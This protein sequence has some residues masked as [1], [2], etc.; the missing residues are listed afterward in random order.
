[1]NILIDIGHPA[2]VHYFRNLYYELTKTHCVWVSCKG[3]KIITD[4]LSAYAIPYTVLGLKANTLVNKASTHLRYIYKA[5]SLIRKH[6][7]D[8]AIGS[9]GIAVHA[10]KLTGI[11]SVLFDDDDQ[12]VQPLTARLV[13]PV[14]GHVVSPDCLAYE[15]IP[16]AV[17]YPGFQELAYLHPNWFHPDCHI[18]KRMGVNPEAPYF[19]LRF[20]AFKAHHDLGEGGMSDSQKNALIRLLEREGHVYI[21]TES[22]LEPE[23]ERYRLPVQPH[24]MHSFLFFASMLVSDSQTMTSE[25]A[26]LGVPSFRCNSFV[27]RISYLEEEEKRYGLTY[28][29][30]PLRFQWMIEKIQM[31]IEKKRDSGY[32][33]AK[34]DAL[35][36][37]KIDVTAYWV[38]LISN[39]P[40]SFYAASKYGFDYDR[41][42]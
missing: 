39:Y 9:S 7:I 15:A 11:D 21:T 5:A 41:F 2:H 19:I 16:R 38:W 31:T 40:Y 8:L 20:N 14:A 37:D 23:F 3:T 12:L 17:Y 33:R 42:R 35:I 30:H 24:E 36:K 29:F 26:V 34:R 32:W 1:M 10:A 4:L 28:G 25:A 13:T 27:G 18:L 6:R 22:K